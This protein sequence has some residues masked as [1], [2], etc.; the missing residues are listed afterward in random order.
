[1]LEVVMKSSVSTF[2]G[3]KVFSATMFAQREL[4]GEQVTEWIGA[5]PQCAIADVVVS[6]SSDASF[7]CIAITVFYWEQTGT[8]ATARRTSVS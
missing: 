6:Q 7:H 8:R 2:N 5:N 1:M 4:L 3:V